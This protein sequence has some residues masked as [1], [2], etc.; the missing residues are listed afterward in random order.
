MN[1]QIWFDLEVQGTLKNLLVYYLG[2]KICS[3]PRTCLSS[4]DRNKLLGV[5]EWQQANARP[6]SLFF[7]P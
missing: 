1:I 2:S 4:L 6:F 5:P 7:S 3:G